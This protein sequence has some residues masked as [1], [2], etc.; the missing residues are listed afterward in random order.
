PARDLNVTLDH[1]R[2]VLSQQRLK[3]TAEV[4]LTFQNNA[5]DFILSEPGTQV[6][7]EAFG[8]WPAGAPVVLKATRPADRSEDVPTQVF[9]AYTL[10]GTAS[11]KIG[12]EQYLM[13][14][15]SSFRWDNVV[16]RDPVPKRN[17]KPPAWADAEPAKTDARVVK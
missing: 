2:I 1:G 11:I 14:A 15:M 7:V 5:Y 13:P 10:K 17:S 8:R 12:D 6:A 9:L 16:G 4:R 3:R